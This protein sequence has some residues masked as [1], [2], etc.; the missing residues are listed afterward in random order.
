MSLLFAMIKNVFLCNYKEDTEVAVYLIIM[1]EIKDIKFKYLYFNI[2]LS[3]KIFECF[4]YSKLK[5]QCKI[6][7]SEKSN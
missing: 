5:K 3:L 4:V 6:S 7:Q 2:E 1:K